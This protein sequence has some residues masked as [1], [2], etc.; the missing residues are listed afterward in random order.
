MATL[1]RRLSADGYLWLRELHDPV[2]VARTR[3]A[4]LDH[5]AEAGGWSPGDMDAPRGR[6]GAY[7]GVR[8]I[9][10]H[11]DVLALEEIRRTYGR[12][13][14]DR[15]HTQ[16][17]FTADHGELSRRTGTRWLSADIRAGDALVFGMDM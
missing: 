8:A 3:T 7:H 14:V 1:R 2:A 15:D 12:S 16:G 4:I 9:S 5:H 11:P 13:D 10:H 17:W 6:G